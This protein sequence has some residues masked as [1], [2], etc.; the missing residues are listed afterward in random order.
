VSS[1]RVFWSAFAAAAVWILDR[2][3][4]AAAVRG[5]SSSQ[6]VSIADP[7][8]AFTLNHNTGA[9]FGLGAHIPGGLTIFATI[10]TLFL[11]FWWLRSVMR[12]QGP[13]VETLALALILG[14]SA[15]NLF[16]RYFYGAVID[17][18]DFKVWPI[19]NVADIAITSGA[20]L[21]AGRVILGKREAA[22]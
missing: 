12:G 11:A 21:W 5:L 22:S 6:S 10:L 16:D 20:V 18:I 1:R 4:K 7:W 3:S 2:A 14:G 19:F 9:A 17:F 13:A 8:L 15:G